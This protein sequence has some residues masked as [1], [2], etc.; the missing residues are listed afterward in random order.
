MGLRHTILAWCLA[1]LLPVGA[2]AAAEVGER[3]GTEPLKVVVGVND[4]Y[5]KDSSCNC[6][7]HIAT[8]QYDDFCRRLREEENIDLR[9]VYF[10]EPYELDR[11]FLA[12]KFDAVLCK[13]WLVLR[14][15]EGRARH[16]VRVADLQDLS[17]NTG[18]WGSVIVPK[19][20]PIQNLAGLSGKRVAIGQADACEKHRDALALFAREGVEIPPGR[21]VEKASCLECLDLLLKGEADAAVISN[22]ALTADCAVDFTTPDAFRVLGKT[23]TIPLTSFIADTGRIPPEGIRRLRSALVDLSAR[24]LPDSMGGGGFVAPAPWKVEEP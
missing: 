10:T 8:R 21:L 18:L 12:G 1:A 6:I 3:K 4:I 22:Y 11:A 23:E 19:D 9:M 2:R 20:S 13:P 15:P 5:C 14:H 17:G 24:A 7:A 16:M